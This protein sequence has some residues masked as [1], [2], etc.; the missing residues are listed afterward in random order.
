MTVTEGKNSEAL[1]LSQLLREM[2]SGMQSP[3]SFNARIAPGAT[4][5]LIAN[6]AVKGISLSNR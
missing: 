4:L 6:A 5:S 3:L 2:S 1:N